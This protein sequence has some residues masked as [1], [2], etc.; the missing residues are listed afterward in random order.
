MIE[1]FGAPGSAFVRKARIVL[2]E[3]GIPFSTNPVCPM[4]ELP[5][6][7]YKI[8][9]LGKIP[10]IKDGEFYLA[11]SSVI[12]SY[13]EKQ[14]PEKNLYPKAPIDYAK[15]IWLEEYADTSLFQALAP[16]YYETILVPLYRQ[17]PIN[18]NNIDEALANKLPKAANYLTSILAQQEHPEFIVA[19]IFSIADISI[20]SMFFNM[21]QAGYPLQYSKWPALDSYLQNIFDRP[22][23]QECIKDIDA[24]KHKL[25]MICKS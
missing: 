13:L 18:Q 15:A 12:C 14:Y 1:L 3:K 21:Y 17:R 11:D 8:S 5:K 2:V 16:M 9:P 7:Y 6:S 4:L 10:A 24:E 23:F 19:N 25:A 22:S 20:A